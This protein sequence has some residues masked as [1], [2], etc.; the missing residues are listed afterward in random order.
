MTNNATQI[1]EKEIAIVKDKII[2]NKVD[3]ADLFVKVYSGKSMSTC[4]FEEFL[5]KLS[6][7]DKMPPLL[8]KLNR[9]KDKLET[10][11]ESKNKIEQA[12]TGSISK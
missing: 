3:I 6:E 4:N 12:K 11:L 2:N 10:L 8:T 9:N 7:M 5:S 1:L